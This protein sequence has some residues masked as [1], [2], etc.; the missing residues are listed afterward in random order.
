MMCL[1]SHS[2]YDMGLIHSFSDSKLYVLKHHIGLSLMQL[3][4]CRLICIDWFLFV[5]KDVISLQYENLGC[6][7]TE[8]TRK[9]IQY[10]HFDA[11]LFKW[12]LFSAS[13]VSSPKKHVLL[14]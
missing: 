13:H 7:L 10:Q 4:F 6:D 14:P 2:S 12:G 3:L 9:A 11:V 5:N 8:K 1:T